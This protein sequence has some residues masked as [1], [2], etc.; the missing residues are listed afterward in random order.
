MYLYTSSPIK[1][2][3]GINSEQ[4]MKK[5]VKNGDKKQENSEE[6]KVAK[7]WPGLH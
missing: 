2:Y 3:G 1:S 7:P 5:D 6:E 4:N